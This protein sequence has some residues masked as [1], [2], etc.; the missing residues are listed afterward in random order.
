MTAKELIQ[1]GKPE[2][3][4]AELLIEVRANPQM[5]SCGCFCFNCW[6]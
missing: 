6:R 1:Q 4:L 3:A 2:E 5:Q